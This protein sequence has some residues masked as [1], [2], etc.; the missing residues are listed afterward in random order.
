MAERYSG[1]RPDMKYSERNTGTLAGSLPLAGAFSGLSFDIALLSLTLLDREIIS[2][3]PSCH[4]VLR[5]VSGTCY[6]CVY[7]FK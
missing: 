5:S 4:H 3:L 6:D 2:R 7:G 1:S